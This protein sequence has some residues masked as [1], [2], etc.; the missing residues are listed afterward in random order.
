VLKNIYLERY[1][2]P[3]PIIDSHPKIGTEIIVVIPCFHEPGIITSLNSLLQCKPPGCRVEVIIVVNHNEKDAEH[4]KNF[5]I[6]SATEIEQWA[7]H[8][9]NHHISFMTIRAFD[10]PKKHAGVGLARKIGMDEAVR[11][12]EMLHE[13]R[14]IIVCFDADSLCSTNYF[15][16]IYACYSNH[17]TVNVALLYFEHPLSGTFSRKTYEAIINYE[18]H[19]R[20]YKNMLKYIG[21]P[22]SYHTIGSCITVTS[23]TYQKQGGMN[24]K[25]AGEDFYFL[26]KVFP[27]GGIYN[28]NSATV[29]P[30][31][32]QSERVPFGTGRAIKEFLK[33]DNE[34]FYTYHPQSFMDISSLIEHS[35]QLYRKEKASSLIRQQP[36]SVRQFLEKINIAPNLNKLRLNCN[37][38][39]QFEKAFFQWFN[40]FA[41]LKFIHFARDNY[42]ENVG[43]LEAA[44]YLL[45]KMNLP[46]VNSI[47]EALLMLRK[48]DKSDNGK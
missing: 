26:Q 1:A 37:T 36:E 35:R 33:K 11:R 44:N 42:Y 32:R 16:E 31:P 24:K 40:G 23:R 7:E 10:L 6:K 3:G 43:V 25:K 4:I 18:L 17:N 12:F 47:K 22:F 19:L 38:S 45:S 46:Q 21:F 34:D 29:T 20:Y 30:S 9:S 39:E 13:E 8:N 14:G 2:W 27:H 48:T 41:I 28:I 5:N 15:K